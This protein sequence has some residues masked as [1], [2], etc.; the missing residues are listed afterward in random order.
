MAIETAFR[1]DRL[2][3]AKTLITRQVNM[4]DLNQ[5]G[6]VGRNL[7]I[8]LAFYL[9]TTKPELEP[10]VEDIFEFLVNKAGLDVSLADRHGC[11]AL[12]YACLNANLDMVKLVCLS[13]RKDFGKMLNSRGRLYIIN[14]RFEHQYIWTV[15][16]SLGRTPLAAALW[17]FSERPHEIR[18]VVS[19]LLEKGEHANRFI[20]LQPISHIQRG[21]VMKKSYLCK[22]VETFSGTP[23]TMAA[24]FGDLKMAELLLRRGATQLPDENRLLPLSHA[25]LSSNKELAKMLLQQD[26]SSSFQPDM[27]RHSVQ[28]NDS[29]LGKGAFV[30]TDM[31]DFVCENIQQC[32]MVFPKSAI[33]EIARAGALKSA[34]KLAKLSGWKAWKSCIVDE[35]E[36]QKWPQDFHVSDSHY[37]TTKD[38]QAM[39]HQLEEQQNQGSIET[40]AHDREGSTSKQLKTLA[41]RSQIDSESDADSETSGTACAYVVEPSSSPKACQV[42]DGELFEG[43]Q[44]TMTKIDVSAGPYG[45]YNFYQMEV[46]IANI[47]VLLLIFILTGAFQCFGIYPFRHHHDEEYLFLSVMEGEAPRRLGLVYQL[48]SDWRLEGRPVSKHPFQE[49]RGSQSRVC[50]DFQGQVWQ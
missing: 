18:E 33:Q 26:D 12:H 48:G 42:S 20:L 10:L 44:I 46:K 11:T 13:G 1:V 43:H 27:V 32:H 23:L 38:A 41:D 6:E 29:A 8:S 3:F 19:Y 50:Q 45:M 40:F 17:K 21:Y 34:A 49:W 9:K 16:D 2:Q 28:F 15:A 5:I 39:L 14:S 47:L 25:L 22:D 24:A 31:F 36:V 4:D 35:F 30:T 37:D 7:L